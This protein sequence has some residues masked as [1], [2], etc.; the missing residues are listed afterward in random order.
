MQ[1]WCE[2]FLRRSG[3]KRLPAA[4]W[5]KPSRPERSA[6]W[7]R[8]RARPPA[9]LEKSAAAVARRAI[10]PT[11]RV[12]VREYAN[13]HPRSELDAAGGVPGARRPDRPSRGLD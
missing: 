4:P 10:G 6:V 9:E 7:Q 2:R 8:T 5:M 12:T 13:A 1:V 11:R 3:P